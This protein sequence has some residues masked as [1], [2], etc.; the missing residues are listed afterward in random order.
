MKWPR[1]GYWTEYSVSMSKLNPEFSSA[2]I[3][4][5]GIKPL[6]GEE[7][8]ETV[9]RALAIIEER[10]IRAEMQ[11]KHDAKRVSEVLDV[12]MRLA[13]LDY[14]GRSGISEAG[15]YIDA[16]AGGVNMLGEELKQSTISLKEKEVLLREIHH[17]VK[18]NLQIISSL[19]NLQ[20]E[21][22]NDVQARQL[23]AV[24]KERVRA[25]AMVHEK[26]YESKDLSGIDFG[27]YIRSLTHGL[28]ISCN[29]D[30]QRIRLKIDV[31]SEAVHLKIDHAVPCA[32]I[33][34]ELVMNGFKHAFPGNR[35]GEI[36]VSLKRN[37]KE[38]RRELV[39]ADN[40]V[41]LPED[42]NADES[43]SLGLQLVTVLSQQVEAE[44]RIERSIG[45]KFTLSCRCDL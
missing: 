26:L 33:L 7:H 43:S 23:Y 44:L 28:N 20:S 4:I 38:N 25:M 10:L 5:A 34:N 11:K 8:D 24:G 17:R 19:L 37:P 40:G 12:V 31:E 41:G 30:P 39:V 42:F 13:A 22:V 14:S 3:R 36:F 35:E 6:D 15:D 27:D 18:N 21:Q 1:S 9:V 2:I 45:T 29:P 32:L 16:L